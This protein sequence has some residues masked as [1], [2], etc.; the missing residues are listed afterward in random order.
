MQRLVEIVQSPHTPPQS[1]EGKN[2]KIWGSMK[3]DFGIMGSDSGITWENPSKTSLPDWTG[4]VQ[5]GFG[6]YYVSENEFHCWKRSRILDLCCFVSHSCRFRR[7]GVKCDRFEKG[8]YKKQGNFSLFSFADFSIPT[9]I[10]KAAARET[11]VQI[12]I[13]RSSWRTYCPRWMKSQGSFSKKSIMR[14]RAR[15]EM[16]CLK[17]SILLWC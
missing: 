15:Q 9:E 8:F 17:H 4:F 2:L 12:S 1:S 5:F 13:V 6:I 16:A 10:Y 3:V 11:D 14:L 7:P